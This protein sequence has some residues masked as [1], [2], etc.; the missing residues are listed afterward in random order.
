MALRRYH[1]HQKGERMTEQERMLL[2]YLADAL[3]SH[4]QWSPTGPKVSEQIWTL[5]ERAKS[6]NSQLPKD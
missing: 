3:R 6:C 1:Q 4:L 5:M 2:L